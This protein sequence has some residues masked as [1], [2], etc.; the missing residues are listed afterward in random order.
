MVVFIKLS[1]IFGGLIFLSI[2]FVRRLLLV[3]AEQKM[4]K[5][6]H[7]EIAREKKKAEKECE[8]PE[9]EEKAIR[10][11]NKPDC[12]KAGDIRRLFK[13]GEYH[14][15]R[16]EYIDAE[17]FFIQV[18]AID[19]THL[20]ANLQLGVTYLGQEIYSK[21]EFFFHKLVNLKKDP[22]YYANLGL[23]LYSQGRLLEA[24]EAYENALSLDDS[25]AARY[26]N[27]AH[28]YRELNNDEKALKNF[29]L[30]S[31]KSPRNKDYL[32]ILIEYYQKIGR[33]ED[34]QKSA[35]RLLDLDPYNEDVKK[36]LN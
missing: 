8:E 32:N 17:K 28:V 15:S 21:A 29:E 20:D 7:R 10:T 3:I 12:T 27:L 34:A 18:L 31:R 11:E 30:A 22:V 26:A 25:R 5:K 19:E 24:A 33:V 6:L 9:E 14:L 2:I 13:K 35:K 23:A 1:I 4:Q 16:K 36:L